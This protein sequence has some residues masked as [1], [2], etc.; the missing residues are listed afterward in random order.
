M[1]DETEE[2]FNKRLGIN[3]EFN[4]SEK[5]YRKWSKKVRSQFSREDFKNGYSRNFYVNYK[6]SLKKVKAPCI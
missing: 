1:I 5:Q 2:E 6:T 3:Y 4:K